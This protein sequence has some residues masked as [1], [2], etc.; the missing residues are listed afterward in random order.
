MTKQ[1]TRTPCGG[2]AT[3]TAH[4]KH[5]T[6]PSPVPP[7]SILEGSGAS[8]GTSWAAVG[9]L[10]GARGRLLDARGRLFGVSWASLGRSWA[11]LGCHML[12][13]IGSGSIFHRFWTSPGPPWS[14]PRVVFDCFFR[15]AN[16]AR[17][18]WFVSR[19]YCRVLWPRAVGASCDSRC[20]HDRVGLVRGAPADG[21]THTYT[22]ART[23][24]RRTQKKAERTG[25]CVVCS[26]RVSC[27]V[28]EDSL[29][30]P[31]SLRT[32]KCT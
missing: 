18:G 30:H 4:E 17:M 24:T 22:Y 21:D 31:T 13:T 15:R 25:G 29:F 3:R 32:Y 16:K 6:I 19:A 14:F 5:A 12:P 1:T 11:S 7:G 2:L 8:S 26:F 23:Q 28:F 9:L 27:A 20:D 10:L